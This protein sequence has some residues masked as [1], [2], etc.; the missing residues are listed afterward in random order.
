MK[1]K[2]KS[3][4][5]KAKLKLINNYLN[6]FLKKDKIHLNYYVGSGS[7]IKK[8]A[9]YTQFLYDSLIDIGINKEDITYSNDALKGGFCGDFIQL[10]S[11]TNF[12]KK[13]ASYELKTKKQFKKDEIQ[14]KEDLKE[15]RIELK[16]KKIQDEI[17]IKEAKDEQE[18][19]HNYFAN[20]RQNIKNKTPIELIKIF[21]EENNKQLFFGNFSSFL[22][23]L[24][25]SNDEKRKIFDELREKNNL[26]LNRKGQIKQ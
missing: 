8:S 5:M 3:N 25:F 4:V 12:K 21:E 22:Y 23:N 16:N 6:S 17:K 19:R 2:Y 10:K 7:R 20:I 18:K 13:L 24:G 1:N 9:N 14:R 26:I 15:Y 11:I